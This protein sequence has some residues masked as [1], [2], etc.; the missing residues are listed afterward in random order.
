MLQETPPA[1]I[2][3]FSNSSRKN[4]TLACCYYFTY[5]T[6]SF[7]TKAGTRQSNSNRKNNHQRENNKDKKTKDGKKLV[8]RGEGKIRV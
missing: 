4:K 3:T 2:E 8:A 1:L 5:S 6:Q 7:K